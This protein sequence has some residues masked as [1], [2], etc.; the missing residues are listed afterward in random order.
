MNSPNYDPLT[1]KII[2]C[3]MEVHKKMGNGFDY[4]LLSD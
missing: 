1:Y 3:A 2:G 4:R